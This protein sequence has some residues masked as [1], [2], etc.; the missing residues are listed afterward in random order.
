MEEKE[1]WKC[2]NY[3]GGVA[4]EIRDGVPAR[5]EQLRI[6]I[7]VGAA[8]GLRGLCVKASR[9]YGDVVRLNHAQLM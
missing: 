2:Q 7:S 1:L 4:D 5:P 3:S 6:N 9:R 8:A